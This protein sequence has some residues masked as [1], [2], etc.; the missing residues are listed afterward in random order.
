MAKGFILYKIYED[1]GMLYLGRTKQDLQSRLRGHFFRKPMHRSVNI[2][3]VT[4]IEYAEFQSE[5][6]MFLY[7]VYLIN[8]FKPPLNVDDKAHDELTV[9]L[10]PVEFREFDCKLMEKWKE[11]ISKQDRVEEFR[12]TERKAA[13]E[14]VAVMRR[15]WHNGEISEEDYYAFKEKIAAM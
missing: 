5:A 7:E 10:P 8:K 9:E 13:L 2:E 12:L 4:K 15:Q 3:R 6:D 14:M 1:W 11:T